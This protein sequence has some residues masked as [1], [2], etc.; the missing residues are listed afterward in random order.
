MENNVRTSDGYKERGDGE[1]KAP[2]S[3]GGQMV[4]AIGEFA[5][6]P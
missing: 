1:I 3:V 2:P 6:S 5:P 4:V